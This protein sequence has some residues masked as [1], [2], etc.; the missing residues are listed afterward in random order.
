MIEI[1]A[2]V[3]AAGVLALSAAA[4]VSV[5]RVRKARARRQASTR[6]PDLPQ[7]PFGLD[8]A[9]VEVVP[10]LRLETGP[11]PF[12]ALDPDNHR[13]RVYWPF[14]GAQG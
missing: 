7:F 12:V 4:L 11:A 6:L 14:E 3:G 9:P 10:A 13:L 8:V 5:H 2:T 1:N